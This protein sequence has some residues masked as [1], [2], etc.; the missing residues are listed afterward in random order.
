MAVDNIQA[1]K[2]VN[3]TVKD[4]VAYDFENPCPDTVTRINN[5]DAAAT[6]AGTAKFAP[7]SGPVAHGDQLLRHPEA[8]NRQGRPRPR[9][10]DP[11]RLYTCLDGVRV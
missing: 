10:V 11:R 6:T 9:R 4:P 5:F 8:C 3:G 7:I 1:V 2:F